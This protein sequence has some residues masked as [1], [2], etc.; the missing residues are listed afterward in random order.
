[1][2]V[3]ENSEQPFI[4]DIQNMQIKVIGTT[5]NVDAY[6]DNT[7]F[8]IALVE[9]SIQLQQ[10]NGD[11]IKDV[12]EMKPNQVAFYN[13]SENKLQLTSE[14]DLSKY[15]AWTDGKIVFSDDPVQTVIQK[16]EKWY[17]VDIEIAD[18]SMERYRFTGTFIDE[19][20]EQVLNIINLTSQMKYQ[21]IP[22]RKLSDNSYSKRKI[23]LKSK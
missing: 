17:N 6:S 16:L 19:P 23:I 12:L 3:I 8:T 7:A 4:V 22:A 18:K 13:Q 20:L 11:E 21:I 15:T 1:V 9:G 10:K 2:K 14:D 5:F